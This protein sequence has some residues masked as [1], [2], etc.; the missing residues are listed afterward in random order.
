MVAACGAKPP[1][2]APPAEPGPVNIEAD[3]AAH[4]R[5]FRAECAARHG[6]LNPG[7]TDDGDGFGRWARLCPLDADRN[8]GEVSLAFERITEDNDVCFSII[9]DTGALDLM[10]KTWWVAAVGS[11][12]ELKGAAWP[13]PAK[14]SSTWKVQTVAARQWKET[15]KY[16]H[17]DTEVDITT[18]HGYLKQELCA[19]NVPMV[20]LQYIVI[21][22]YVPLDKQQ[23]SEEFLLANPDL[24]Q[25]TDP[26]IPSTGGLYIW[27]VGEDPKRPL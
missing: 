20:D 11:L 24:E 21:F 10:T 4:I 23:L 13:P 16:K 26:P 15:E 14:T 2:V 5:F 7:L 17:G 22:R 9:G 6:R 1:L 25:N 12:D 18:K 8:L 19:A 27:T 3:I